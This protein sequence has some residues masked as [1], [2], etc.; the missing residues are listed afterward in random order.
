MSDT[1]TTALA[2]SATPAR[3]SAGHGAASSRTI[4]FAD[5]AGFHRTALHMAVA[6]GLAGLAAHVVTLLEPKLGTMGSPIPVAAVAGAAVY[7][8]ASPET[9]A[10][11]RDLATV[12]LGAAFAAAALAAVSRGEMAWAWGMTIFAGALGLLFGRGQTGKRFWVA[13]GAG[14][15]AVLAGKFVMGQLA[16]VSF[17]PPWLVAGAAGISF[18]TVALLGTLP[19]HLRWVTR[20]GGA[21]EAEE[22]L[23]RARA[24]A[25]QCEHGDQAV[26]QSVR[27]EVD[28]LTEVAA[29]F[30]ELDRQAAVSPS[31]ADLDARVAELD[32][33]IEA[34]TDEMA[35]S[36]FER[37]RQTVEA[38]RREVKSICAGRERVLARMHAALA[39]IESMRLTAVGAEIDCASQALLEAEEAERE[40]DPSS[41]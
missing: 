33:R 5:H 3:Q 21:S 9:R 12:V 15:A 11:A 19:R 18:G 39:Q 36:Q 38:Q 28:R 40:A 1:T 35:K 25:A 20:T 4:G 31:S 14:A 30:A 7:G 37:A 17:G 13:T 23:A 6:G 24:V 29:R 34:A 26:R 8:A 22:I 41:N 16:M 2:P 10:K 32:R 27:A